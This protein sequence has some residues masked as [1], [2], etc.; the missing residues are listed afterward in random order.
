MKVDRE[1]L[2]AALNAASLVVDPG[3]S[4]EVFSKVWLFEDYVLGFNASGLVIQVP[5]PIPSIGGVDGKLLA[6]LLDKTETEKIELITTDD[7]QLLVTDED[8]LHIKMPVLEETDVVHTVSEIP[9]L[10]EDHLIEGDAGCFL[11]EISLPAMLQLS[12]LKSETMPEFASLVIDLKA[13][14]ASHALPQ[15][16]IYTSDRQTINRTVFK[17]WEM[18]ANPGRYL[19]PLEFVRTLLRLADVFKEGT[20][21]FDKNYIVA[22]NEDGAGLFTRLHQT[23]NNVDFEDAILR[24]WPDRKLK[25]KLMVD[26]PSELKVVLNQAKLVCKADNDIVRLVVS[27]GTLKVTAEGGKAR[28]SA[29]LD[30]E[31]HP[32]AAVNLNCSRLLQ[33]LPHANKMLLLQNAAAFRGPNK[34]WRF[35]AGR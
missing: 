20:I 8:R 10:N 14:E 13:G 31:N 19:V 21:A 22:T 6:Q 5:C 33:V 30:L 2:L 4:I 11:E 15:A 18:K 35:I 7:G 32:P 23:S 17:S 27:D 9:D 34:F 29:A 1:E 12:T 16:F 28:Y 26:I 3:H 24:I 25:P